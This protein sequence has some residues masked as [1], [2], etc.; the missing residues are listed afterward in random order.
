MKAFFDKVWAWIVAHKI[1]SIVIA[2]VLV[3]G[4]TLA[5]VLPLTL[6]GKKPSEQADG[7]GSGNKE[8][9]YEV[10]EEQFYA[11]KRLKEKNLTITFSTV[12]DGDSIDVAIYQLADGSV[13]AVQTLHSKKGDEINICAA[14][15]DDAD[16]EKPYAYYE[17]Y[18]V[19]AGNKF[20][21][22][23]EASE[24]MTKIEARQLVGIG[25]GSIYDQIDMV[26]NWAGDFY[27][28]TYVPDKRVY[29]TRITDDGESFDFYIQFKDGKLAT[30]EISGIE[31]FFGDYDKT[32]FPTEYK[33]NEFI[34]AKAKNVTKNEFF[35]IVKNYYDAM[36]FN[37][38]VGGYG[39]IDAEYYHYSGGNVEDE[40]FQTIENGATVAKLGNKKYIEF[41]EKVGNNRNYYLY[42]Y[43]EEK[44]YIENNEEKY[45][46]D[47]SKTFGE[48]VGK[49]YA[50]AMSVLKEIVDAGAASITD[51]KFD[52]GIVTA[53]VGDI[54]ICAYVTP[55][56][57]N[58][59]KLGLYGIEIASDEGENHLILTIEDIEIYPA[60][61]AEYMEESYEIEFA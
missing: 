55:D 21:S 18:S 13:F 11:A 40:P 49:A 3:A 27:D 46:K 30:F 9:V 15:K 12:E 6:G 42:D 16:E 26:F 28:W 34:A 58:D 39:Y 24:R 33:L 31:L 45:E 56:G 23:W 22:N 5:I 61:L 17:G 51:Y 8:I 14:V 47:T 59:Y 2:A 19:N 10:T 32:V 57:F 50:S 29:K 7:D 35:A 41:S 25:S 20:Y 38:A 53:K 4:I 48:N 52:D 44:L 43:A 36:T 60:E 54:E 37:A 1:V